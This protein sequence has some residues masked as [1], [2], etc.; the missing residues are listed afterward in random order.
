VNDDRE[1]C[2]AKEGSVYVKSTCDV[3]PH[4]FHF[5]DY[6]SHLK[7]TVTGKCICRIGDKLV[8]ADHA[9]VNNNLFE[10]TI[11]DGVVRSYM[12]KYVESDLTLVYEPVSTQWHLADEIDQ[13]IAETVAEV[14]APAPVEEVPAP[15]EVEETP[16][17]EE[18]PAPV[19]VEEA[20]VVEEVEDVPVSR[21]SALIEE[22]LNVQ[23]AEASASAEV[24]EEE[25]ITEKEDEAPP[26]EE[27]APQV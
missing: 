16:V 5:D 6:T 10:W 15:V 1:I 19:E 25:E 20:P 17:V 22:A 7:N 27:A 2:L 14:L 12:D 24:E 26:A 3:P 18:V 8:E 11:N 23:A 13:V 21:A 4:L 9:G